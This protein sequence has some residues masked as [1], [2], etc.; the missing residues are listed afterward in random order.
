M[1]TVI[2][3]PNFLQTIFEAIVSI[4]VIVLFGYSIEVGTKRSTLRKCEEGY[5][6]KQKLMVMFRRLKIE[7]L[8]K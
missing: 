1:S 7:D 4:L 6:L 2:Q 5:D 3:E 8:E